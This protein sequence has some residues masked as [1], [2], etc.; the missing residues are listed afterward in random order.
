MRHWGSKFKFDFQGTLRRSSEK[1]RKWTKCFLCNIYEYRTFMFKYPGNDRVSWVFRF[2]VCAYHHS[3]ISRFEKPAFAALKPQKEKAKVNVIIWWA[4]VNK[5]G[6]KTPSSRTKIHR[7]N[8][9]HVTLLRKPVVVG[10]NEFLGQMI[11]HLGRA[12]LCPDGSSLYSA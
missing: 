9:S 3:S 11:W 1:E 2:F 4:A 8:M 6:R 7:N 12:Y 10:T 5:N